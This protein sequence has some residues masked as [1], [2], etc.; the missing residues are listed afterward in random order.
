MKTLQKLT[1]VIG[2]AVLILAIAMGPATATEAGGGGEEG[3]Q[4]IELPSSARDQVGLILFAVLG[5]GGVLALVNAR[6][7]LRGERK[8]A[9]GDFRWR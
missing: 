3:P 8:Q 4:K 2:A 1:V 7:Q 5:A 6:K 9:S